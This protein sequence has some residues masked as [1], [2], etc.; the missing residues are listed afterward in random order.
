MQE[1]SVSFFNAIASFAIIIAHF[2]NCNAI[3][4]TSLH[5]IKLDL[6]HFK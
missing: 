1:N 5:H 3:A 6:K 4:S 2:I